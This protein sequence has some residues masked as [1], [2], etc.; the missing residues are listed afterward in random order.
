[1]S[2]DKAILTIK[3][4]LILC[5]VIILLLL[6]FAALDDI[7]TNKQPGYFWEYLMLFASILIFIFLGRIFLIKSPR[8]QNKTG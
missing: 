4:V 8:L 3:N 6:D 5:F 2:R 7:T 1:M